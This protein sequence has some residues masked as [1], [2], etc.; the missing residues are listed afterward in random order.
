MNVVIQPQTVGITI[1]PQTM[2]VGFSPPIIR[3][4]EY[5]REP[6]EGSYTITPTT[7]AQ[8]LQTENLRMTDNL[9]IEP[10]P[11]NYGLI[12]WNGTILTVS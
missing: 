2:G 6:Y 8:I 5:D 12:T 3:D 11:S 7:S 1:N 4:Y 10:I 9:T